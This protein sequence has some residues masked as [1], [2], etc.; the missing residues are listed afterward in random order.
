MSI[1]KNRK[2]SID[3]KMT[4]IICIEDP[5]DCD[6]N[7]TANTKYEVFNRFLEYIKHIALKSDM[8]FAQNMSA[9]QVNDWGISKI[10]TKFDPTN[11]YQ[12]FVGRHIIH[13]SV[14]QILE[15]PK[16]TA[17]SMALALITEY[18]DLILLLMEKVFRVLPLIKI[19]TELSEDVNHC[20]EFTVERKGIFA[21]IFDSNDRRFV[22]KGLKLNQKKDKTQRIDDE[23]RITDEIIG[24]FKDK[25]IDESPVKF[26]FCLF[27][28]NRL[29]GLYIE[30]KTLEFSP[31]ESNIDKT[32][33]NFF[34]LI[35]KAFELK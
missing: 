28:H 23:M 31:K 11:G 18:F 20:V 29:T 9:N 10:I 34:H 3:F 25:P 30:F 32:L 21:K 26:R 12:P 7:L 1:N 2:N 33:K 19:I 22:R 6:Y 17:Q 16:T 13:P 15:T 4:P 35:R 14:R 27:G 8:I 24:K 5:F